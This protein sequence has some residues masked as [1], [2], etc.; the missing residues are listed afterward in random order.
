[1][2]NRVYGW[3]E[4]LRFAH[5]GDLKQKK[6]KCYFMC[7]YMFLIVFMFML[8]MLLNWYVNMHGCACYC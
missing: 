7:V 4:R 2:N 5:I 8:I 1:M 3:E 6:D